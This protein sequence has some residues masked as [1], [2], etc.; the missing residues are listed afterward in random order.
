MTAERDAPSAVRIPTSF[1]LWAARSSSRL[2][3]FAHAMSS[4]KKTAPIIVVRSCRGCGP[5]TDSTNDFTAA[6][7]CLLVAG[8]AVARRWAIAWISALA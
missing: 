7:T 4:T 1:V 3:T 2:A 8:Y 5:I 6:P